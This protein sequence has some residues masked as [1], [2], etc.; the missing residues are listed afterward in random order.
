LGL[1]ES[2]SQQ[3][4]QSVDLDRSEM[5][6]KIKVKNKKVNIITLFLILCY[7]GY[8]S[9]SFSLKKMHSDEFT[10]SLDTTTNV[11]SLMPAISNTYF[12]FL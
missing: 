3:E 11:F 2:E 10:V 8:F 7:L 12:F 4:E 5:F 9:L 1:Q 6:K